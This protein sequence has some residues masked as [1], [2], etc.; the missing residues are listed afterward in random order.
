MAKAIL[1]RGDSLTILK[2]IRNDTVGVVV[3]D[4]PYT[5]SYG[6]HDWDGDGSLKPIWQECLRVLKPGGYL[7]AF[8]DHRRFHKT[9]AELEEIGFTFIS[10]M[11]WMYPNG[12][13]ACQKIDEECHARVK[14]SHEPLGIFM[15]PLREKTYKKHRAKYGNSGLRVKNT[16]PG[17]KM[18]TSI[19]QYNKPTPTERNL[20]V[21]HLPPR[22]VNPRKESGRSLQKTTKRGNHHPCVKPIELMYHLCRLVAQPG[23]TVLDPFMGSGATGMA[24]IWNNQNFIGIELDEGY[25]EVAKLRVEYALNN[26]RPTFPL[27]AAHRRKLAKTEKSIANPASQVTPWLEASDNL[28]LLVPTRRPKKFREAIASLLASVSASCLRSA[29]SSNRSVNKGEVSIGRHTEKTLAIAGIRPDGTNL[30]FYSLPFVE[31][32]PLVFDNKNTPI[33]Q[34]RHEVRV[35]LGVGQLKPEGRFLALDVPYPVANL[36]VP[37][38]MNRAVEFF[39]GRSQVSDKMCVV[40]VEL[41][42]ARIRLVRCVGLFIENDGQ[43]SAG[44]KLV[45]IGRKQSAVLACFAFSAQILDELGHRLPQ[46]VFV[47]GQHIQ[48]KPRADQSINRTRYEHY[49]TW[50]GDVG[51][52]DAAIKPV[53]KAREGPGRLFDDARQLTLELL[54]KVD[55][56]L[57]FVADI[58]CSGPAGIRHTKPVLDVTHIALVQP[59]RQVKEMLLREELKLALLSEPKHRHDERRLVVV[60]GGAGLEVVG[61]GIEAVDGLTDLWDG[62]QSKVKDVPALAGHRPLVRDRPRFRIERNPRFHGRRQF[63]NRGGDRLGRRCLFRQRVRLVLILFGGLREAHILLRGDDLVSFQAIETRALHKPRLELLSCCVKASRHNVGVRL[64]KRVT[65]FPLGLRHPQNAAQDL[66]HRYG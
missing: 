21:E 59:P 38:E 3:C 10:G 66:L 28:S 33:G 32:L 36:F 48:L 47:A 8:G 6:G 61:L 15:K 25:F 34:H 63:L 62:R 20:G 64:I 31:M 44:R 1:K 54:H 57:A 19:L 16:I 65:P 35:K 29:M 49:R 13:P 26:L 45:R 37:V 18:T 23:D 2:S 5:I 46:V 30:P 22:Q 51:V 56:N 7:A 40:L 52:N 55:F 17:I 50:L 24:A 58:D 41:G 12:T 11:A 9:V 39:A 27:T 42:S 14:P 60:I 43:V 53:G 4:P